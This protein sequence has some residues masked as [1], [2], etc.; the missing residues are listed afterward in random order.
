MIVVS[1]T[2]PL[3][4]LILINRFY[5]LKEIFQFVL[6]PTEVAA[7]LNHISYFKSAIEVNNSW[8][9]IVDVTN[10]SKKAEL[11]LVL[12][13]GESAAIALAIEQ[14]ANLLLID[15]RKGKAIAENIGIHT[16]GTLGILLQAK[17]NGLIK[18]IKNDL[19]KLRQHNFWISDQLI[20]EFLYWLAKNN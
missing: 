20:K 18:E 9:N 4:S 3:S 2:T 1:D 19:Y 7:E 13:E 14:N 5:L 6:I 10:K 11:M 12:D 17:R 8:I 15:E 16:T